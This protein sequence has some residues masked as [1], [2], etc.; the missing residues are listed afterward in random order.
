MV[1]LTPSAVKKLASLIREHPEDPYV[2]LTLLD[3][4]EQRIVLS[5]TLEDK[6]QPDDSLQE[7]EG[8][9][10]AIAADT[11]P[12]MNGATIDYH[13]AAGFKIIHPEPEEDD[14]IPLINLN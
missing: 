6:P 7:I 14:S 5:I 9:T 4:D 12:R 2:R 1:H 13:E 3:V 11:A 8:L 10:V